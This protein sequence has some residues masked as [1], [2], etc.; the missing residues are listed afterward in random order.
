MLCHQAH[1]APRVVGGTLLCF[2]I[3][4]QQVLSHK[5]VLFMEFCL[6]GLVPFS[7]CTAGSCWYRLR[8]E[9][10]SSS[11]CWQVCSP[12]PSSSL[13]IMVR[14]QICWSAYRMPMLLESALP[15]LYTCGGNTTWQKSWSWRSSQ[16]SLA[17]SLF[18]NLAQ[19]LK[20]L[21]VDDGLGSLSEER[22]Y[23]AWKWTKEFWVGPCQALRLLILQIPKSRWLLTKF[24]H[25]NCVSINL[26]GLWQSTAETFSRD[27]DL[28]LFVTRIILNG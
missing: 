4:L 21:R 1:T 28:L 18:E 7:T 26:V 5:I 8:L 11:R 22:C 9:T 6:T 10:G 24:R 23:F 3:H 27:K 13:D 16:K 14:S 25:I 19:T 12:M 2:Q 17:L 20:I 15:Q